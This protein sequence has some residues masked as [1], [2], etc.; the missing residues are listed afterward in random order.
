MPTTNYRAL[1]VDDEW[2]VRQLTKNALTSAGIEC[3]IAANGQQAMESIRKTSYDVVITDLMMPQSNG[4]QLCLRLLRLPDRP[5][6]IVLTGV[7][8]TKI[9]TDLMKRGI[10]DIEF[11]PVDYY[12]FTA[13]ILTLLACRDS[14]TSQT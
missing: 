8:S 3:H 9:G 6:I 2:T 7:R 1:I 4:H 14:A 13:K 10:D 12:A 11:K 5:I